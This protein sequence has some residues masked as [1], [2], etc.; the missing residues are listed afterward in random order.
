VLAGRGQANA[1]RL[2]RRRAAH[3]EGEWVREAARVYAEREDAVQVS[4]LERIAS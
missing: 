1:I 3:E 2:T 4:E